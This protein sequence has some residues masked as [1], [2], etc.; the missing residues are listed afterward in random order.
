M[1]RFDL[2]PGEIDTL[3]LGYTPY[4]FAGNTLQAAAARWLNPTC[5]AH[6]LTL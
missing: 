4:P 5:A 1:G 3:M 6:P 2:K